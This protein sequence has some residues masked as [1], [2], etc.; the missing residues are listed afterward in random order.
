MFTIYNKEIAIKPLITKAVENPLH[1]DRNSLLDE[2]EVY[3]HQ[4]GAPP[5]LVYFSL[6]MV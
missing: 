5:H 2:A 3:F 4:G 6:A 1:T